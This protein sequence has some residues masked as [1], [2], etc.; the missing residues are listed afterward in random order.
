M[1]PRLSQRS[2]W[3][4]SAALRL[5][6]TSIPSGIV[7]INGLTLLKSYGVHDVLRESSQYTYHQGERRRGRC[8]TGCIRM[9]PHLALSY[10]LVNGVKSRNCLQVN[11]SGFPRPCRSSKRLPLYS[12]RYIALSMWF[13]T[14]ICRHTTPVVT[15]EVV[16]NSN[17]PAGLRRRFRR[18]IGSVGPEQP[19]QTRMRWLVFKPPGALHPYHCIG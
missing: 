4:P 9:A 19:R 18:G 1:R 12:A 3:F 16:R 5:Y 14:C 8:Q 10:F 13:P 11:S 6:R 15:C 17:S 2:T 7:F